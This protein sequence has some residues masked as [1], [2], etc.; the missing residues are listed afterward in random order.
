MH[1]LFALI[2]VL[3]LVAAGVMGGQTEAGRFAFTSIVPYAAFLLLLAGFCRRVIQWALVPV[4]FHIPVTCGQQRSLDWIPAA[5]IDNPST[6][7]GVVGRMTGEI[8][9]FRS[10]FRNSKAR[11]EGG[12]L[13]FGESKF[14]WLSALAFHWALLL[15][16]LR[17][18]RFFVE[19]VPMFINILERTDSYFQIGTPRLYLSD[20]IL[21][22]ALAYLIVRRF[23]DPVLRFISQFTDYFALFLL[24]GIAAS[25]MLMRYFT[26]IDILSVKQIAL[27]F[28]AFRPLTSQ[29]LSPLFHVHILLVCTLAAYLPFSKLMHAGG[30]FLSPTRNLVNDS[31][32]RRHINPWN[33]PVKTHRYAEWEEEF[34]AKLIAAD[35]PR[36]A[37]D[38]GRACSH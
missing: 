16:L 25:G 29:G 20:L 10:L 26:R 18:L 35:I 37:E 30:T 9:L 32:A 24:L 36:E 12:R 34:R 21:L 38:A 5:K 7:F 2:A 17:H 8:F 3:A 1:A 14:L 13:I 31:R 19:P 11:L 22:G 15:I 33:S 28:A 6:Q 27:G 4:P 23:R